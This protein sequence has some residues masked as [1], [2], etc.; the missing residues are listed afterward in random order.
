M[1]LFAFLD[2]KRHVGN[3]RKCQERISSA[4]PCDKPTMARD[5]TPDTMP[6]GLQKNAKNKAKRKSMKAD[7]VT[8]CAGRSAIQKCRHQYLASGEKRSIESWNDTVPQKSTRPTDIAMEQDPVI[9][10]YLEAKLSLF[11]RACVKGDDCSTVKR[12][13]SVDSTQS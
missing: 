6:S 11:R 7:S 13:E 12:T 1:E 5:G 3:S 10:Q 8:S 2:L 9:Q 4:F